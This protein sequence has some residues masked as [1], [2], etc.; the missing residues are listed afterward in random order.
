MTDV[1][2][3]VLTA[4][5]SFEIQRF[6]RP[7]IGDEDALLRVEACGICGSDY[8]QYAGELAARYP[9][10]PGHEPIGIIEEIGPLASSRWGVETGD[11]VAVR[12]RYSC[13]QCRGCREGGRCIESRGMYGYTSP[14]VPP[15]LWGGYAEYLYLAPGSIVHRI[16]PQVPARLAALAN[17]I[18]AGFAWAQRA[19]GL[20]VGDS[21]AV[22]GPG[23]RGLASVV[24]ARE[25]G[26][27]TVIVTGLGRD[28]AKMALAREFGADLTIDVEA[29]DPVAAVMEATDGQGVD[30][31]VDTTPY[32][33]DAV[34][35]AL[36][37]VRNGGTVVLAGLKGSN[38]VPEFPSD[39]IIQKSLTVRGVMGVDYDSFV[40]AIRVIESGKYPLEKMHTHEFPLEEADRAIRTLSGEANEPA[41]SVTIEP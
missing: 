10:I 34:I 35:Q 4:V 12:S 31:V 27:G 16:S 32:A 11:R 8:E 22:L 9:V 25:A 41:I 40:T 15:S 38:R 17:P 5:R 28:E 30:R 23:Q 13:G 36:D 3:A 19:A 39:R 24:A 2:A 18:G 7:A 20:S 1:K 29:Q 21:I 37:M 14:D 33:T 26:A 6:P